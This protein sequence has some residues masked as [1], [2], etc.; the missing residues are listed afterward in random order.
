MRV[1]I[2]GAGGQLG[3]DLLGVFEDAVGLTRD[4]LD[5]ADEPAVRH[6]V[7]EFGPRLVV[8]AA[9][10]TDVDACEADP[11]RAHAVNA[12]GPWWLARAC[13]DTG[14][15]LLTVSTDYVFDGAAPDGPDGRGFVETDLTRPL[16]AYG[17]SKLAGEQLVRD[18]LA[19]HYV[20]R[21]AWLFGAH[22][23]NFVRTMLRVG[24]ERGA[25]RVVDDQVGSPTSTRDLADAIREIAVSGRFG[26]YHRT[27]AGRAS[28]FEQ[29]AAVFELAGLDVDLQ[30]TSSADLDR[31]A[32]RP[33]FSVL[34]NRHAEVCGLRG[35]P[36]WRDALARTLADLGE[37]APSR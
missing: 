8:N 33:A 36:P 9:A 25:A 2:T 3:R 13:H 15:A 4:E 30:P 17:R 34:D 23:D 31:P 20:V 18:T 28:R 19:T 11:D 24:R 7:E 27:N 21:T 1:L 32:R 6:A 26:T 35:L 14:A 29:A 22:G 10:M 5:V 16:S 37:L 12:L